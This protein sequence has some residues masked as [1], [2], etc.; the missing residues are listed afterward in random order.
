MNHFISQKQIVCFSLMTLVLVKSLHAFPIIYTPDLDPDNFNFFVT[1]YLGEGVDEDFDLYF[2]IP[3]A[4][5]SVWPMSFSFNPRSL[6]VGSK[7]DLIWVGVVPPDFSMEVSATIYNSEVA[8]DFNGTSLQNAVLMKQISYVIQSEEDI[9]SF[10]DI[11]QN[12][13][14]NQ[15]KSKYTAILNN[16]KLSYKL[17]EDQLKTLPKSSEGAK[18]PSNAKIRKNLADLRRNQ[19]LLFVADTTLA[20][21]SNMEE[22]MDFPNLMSVMYSFNASEEVKITNAPTRPS[23]DYYT[24]FAFLEPF[25]SVAERIED[26]RVVVSRLRIELNL[27][28]PEPFEEALDKLCNG[29]IFAKDFVYNNLY[30]AK[31]KEEMEEE[32]ER[33]M[34]I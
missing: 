5:Q 20:P 29:V 28:L 24:R 23:M 21:K 27:E 10:K 14:M 22:V 6:Q 18:G 4:N 12:F 31:L 9:Q 8:S 11:F 1:E 34:I 30:S 33:R 3:I 2:D 15:L 7:V 17:V 26:P 32:E 19:N 16:I 25:D 13:N